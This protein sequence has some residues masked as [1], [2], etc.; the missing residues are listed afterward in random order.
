M[1]C[2]IDAH[3]LTVHLTDTY[4]EVEDKD[5]TLQTQHFIP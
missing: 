4:Q 1:F 5:K 3:R 2:I